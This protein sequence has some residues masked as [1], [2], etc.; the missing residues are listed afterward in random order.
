MVRMNGHQ[1]RFAERD[2]RLRR[3]SVPASRQQ[4]MCLIDDQPVR[5][6]SL[7]PSSLEGAGTVHRKTPA[8]RL[9]GLPE[10]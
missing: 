7:C 1:D 5:P 3:Q 4:M 10:G 2:R 6:R 8:G 9:V